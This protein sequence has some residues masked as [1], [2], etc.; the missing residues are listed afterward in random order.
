MTRWDE[1]KHPRDDDG[2][3]TEG[4]A[5]AVASRLAPT[6]G[7]VRGRDLDG[8]LDYDAMRLP[9]N[10]DGDGGPQVWVILNRTAVVVEAAT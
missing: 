1:A 4:W 10:D 5:G 7:H 9:I 6:A 8:E 3:F 2:R